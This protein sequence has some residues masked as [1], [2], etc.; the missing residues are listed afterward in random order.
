MSDLKIQ[1]NLTRYFPIHTEEERFVDAT[2]GDDDNDG[3][4]FATA[5]QTLD[6][7]LEWLQ[8]AGMQQS[9]ILTIRGDF[10]V[11]H[12]LNVGG[13]SLGGTDGT[14]NTSATVPDNWVGR[15]QRQIRA[16]LEEVLT[17][18][19]ILAESPAP[20]ATSGLY[21]FTVDQVLVAGAHVGQFLVGGALGEWATI[22]DNDVNTIY[23][24]T[25]TNPATWTAPLGI[26]QYGATITA[27]DP[28]DSFS[29]ATE[30]IARCDWY[31]NGIRFL[32]SASQVMA[33]RMM[34]TCPVYLQFC[35]I[36][37]M[38][39]VG[40]GGIYVNV[41]CCYINDS[42]LSFDG[43]DFIF[44]NSF[45]DGIDFLCHGSGAFADVNQCAIH[46]HVS[47][48]GGGVT[49]SKF[50]FS[51]ANC[52][53]SNGLADGV[54]A[55]FGKSRMTN[56]LV[57]GN[58]GDGIEVTDGAHLLLTTVSGD[59]GDFGCIITE[60][61]S[62]VRASAVTVDGGSGEVSLGDAGATTWA[63]APQVDLGQLCRLVS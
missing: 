18:I 50:M 29:A 42:T 25:T 16:P 15:S 53:V 36:K 46:S 8:V 26:Y 1:G 40:S 43:A 20:N 33:L 12:Q 47:P 10:T 34:G 56:V 49:L 11:A 59:N 22:I 39:L 7:A 41:D 4:S 38:Q 62:Q 45:M 37:G 17:P 9:R 54:S 6:H 51:M 61:G 13:A 35:D 31:F 2:A 14:F 55:R 32:P 48:F 63:A 28:V 23:V 57:D 21:T 19:T 60:A 24:A 3:L 58:A 5:W 52:D 27:G 44:R 30:L